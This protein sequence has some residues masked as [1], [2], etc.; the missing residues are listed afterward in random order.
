MSKINRTFTMPVAP[1]RAQDMFCQDVA[2]EVHRNAEIPLVRQEPGRLTFA[3]LGTGEGI[4]GGI[5]KI[6]LGRP[7]FDV[8]FEPDTL[9]TTVLIRGRCER[10]LCDAL[11]RLGTPG[12]WPETAGRPHD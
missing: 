1:E 6:R 5:P 9:G 10:E 7:H 8:T 4:T 3:V 11:E 12:H 2:A